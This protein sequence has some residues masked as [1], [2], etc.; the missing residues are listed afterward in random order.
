MKNGKISIRTIQ[1]LQVSIAFSTQIS[2]NSLASGGFPQ[3]PL[4]MHISKFCHNFRQ[5]FDKIFK[6]FEKSRNFLENLKK[7]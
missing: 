3:N 2:I 7:L 6:K 5:K 1:K 4:E